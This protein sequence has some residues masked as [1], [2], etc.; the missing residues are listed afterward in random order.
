MMEKIPDQFKQLAIDETV[1]KRLGDP[2]DVAEVVTFLCSDLSKHVTGE[3]IKVDGGQY[4]W[5]YYSEL[6]IKLI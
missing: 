3:V 5:D 6:L 2:D 4:I 1:L